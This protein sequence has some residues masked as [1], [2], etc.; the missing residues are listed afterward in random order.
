MDSEQQTSQ[1]WHKGTV[2][3]SKIKNL[4]DIGEDPLPL[5]YKNKYAYVEGRLR[6][7]FNDPSL[8]L[9]IRLDT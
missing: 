9:V 6:L 3:S 5:A 8:K 1:Q 4:R 2:C 7:L